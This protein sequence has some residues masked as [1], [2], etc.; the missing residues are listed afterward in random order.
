VQLAEELRKILPEAAILMM[1]G[2]IDGLSENAL[3]KIGIT[4]FVNK[5]VPLGPLRQAVLKLARPSAARL[6][7]PAR[8]G[9]SGWLSAGLGSRRD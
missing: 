8:T 2:K 1:S 7:R 3:Q 9:N 4:V 5:P 6:P